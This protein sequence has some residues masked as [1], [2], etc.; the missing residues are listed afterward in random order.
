MTKS[1]TDILEDEYP[2]HIKSQ[3]IRVL[4]LDKMSKALV[5]ADDLP[6]VIKRFNEELA[7][8]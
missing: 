2:P 7:A 6:A 4:L 3:E 1:L 8:L 5:E